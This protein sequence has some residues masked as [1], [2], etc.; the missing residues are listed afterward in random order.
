MTS[1]PLPAT[2][3]ASVLL[4]VTSSAGAAQVVAALHP[5]ELTSLSAV[6]FS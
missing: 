3:S 4:A 1:A 6:Y 2:S 5:P